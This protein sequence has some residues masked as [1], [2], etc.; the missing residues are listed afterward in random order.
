MRRAARHVQK[1]QAR[2][3]TDEVRA[4]RDDLRRGGRGDERGLA[5]GGTADVG[6]A[7]GER[8]ADGRELASEGGDVVLGISADGNSLAGRGVDV[9]EE[10]GRADGVLAVARAREVV[11]GGHW[12]QALDTIPL[13]YDTGRGTYNRG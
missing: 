1:G 11:C 4:A 12:K 7:L 2:L 6:R 8:G 10:V 13:G 3:E 5:G 9:V